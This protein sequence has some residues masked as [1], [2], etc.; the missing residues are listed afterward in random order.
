MA[1]VPRPSWE[2]AYELRRV[3]ARQKVYQPLAP[4]A[5]AL[6]TGVAMD[7]V[8]PLG[9]GWWALAVVAL[10]GWLVGFYQQRIQLALVAVL[11]AV[12]AVGGAWSHAQW[13]LFDRTELGRYAREQ[14]SPVCLEAIALDVPARRPAPPHSPY[15]AIPQRDSTKLP[16]RVTRIRDGNQWQ[17]AAGVVDLIVDGHLEGVA[18]GDYLRLFGQLRRPGKP[19]NPGQFDFAANAR[20]D[21]RLALLRCESPACVTRVAPARAE[22]GS[23]TSHSAPSLASRVWWS[24][25]AARQSVELGLEEQLG[26]ER[27]P[28]AAAMLLGSRHRVPLNVAE[29]FRRTGALHVLVVS[30][31]HVGLVVGFFFGASRLGWFPRRSTLMLIMLAIAAYALFT[32]ARPPVVRAAV[33]AEVMCVAMLAGRNVLAINSLAAAVIVVLAWNPGELFLSGTQLTFIATA[34]LIWLGNRLQQRDRADPMDRLLASVES[35]PTRFAKRLLNS[36][37]LLLLATLFVWCI[38]APLLMTRFHLLSPIAV[39]MSLGVFPLV[40]VTVIAALLTAVLQLFSPVLAAAPAWCCGQ[41]IDALQAL[42]SSA[43][44][45]PGST[46]WLGGPSGWWTLGA[47]GLLTMGLLYGTRERWS[48]WLSRMGLLWIATGFVIALVSNRPPDGVRCTFIAVGHGCSVLVETPEGGALLYDAGSLG[49]P[50]AAAE[51]IAGALWSKGIGRIDAIVLSHPDVDHF[52]AVPGL[53]DRFPIG[54]IYV[55]PFM[56]PESEAEQTDRSAPASLR[57]LLNDHDVPVEVI[58]QGD[59]LTIDGVAIQI[60]HPGHADLGRPDNANSLVLAF[61]YQGRRLLLP[62]DLEAPGMQDVLFQSSYNCDLLLAP[63]HGSA[64]SDPP[65]FAKWSSPEWVVVSGGDGRYSTSAGESYAQAG[66]CVLKT[67]DVGAIEVLLGA[68]QT[69]IK[70]YLPPPEPPSA[71]R[72]SR[73]VTDEAHPQSDSGYSSL[74]E[75]P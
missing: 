29:S 26:P 71:G 57:K 5:V 41:S 51:T 68:W 59:Q 42:I 17:P 69:S 72:Q 4:V 24:I 55:S 70:T 54:G 31:L 7:R 21:H 11:V 66:A 32:G 13:R 14:S 45:V 74:R 58:S 6:A 75:L 10:A 67:A 44:A 50:D 60:L 22:R 36:A 38:S 9:A 65:G 27:A 1:E 48:Y 3:T 15:R 47:Y 39:P 2:S 12:A 30:G 19:R 56:F 37:S 61:E 8:A 73:V 64:R 63:H 52:N 62:G 18:P 49:S 16:L 20:A 46:I 23:P 43:E 25:A 34:A 33:L 28:L 53:L 40:S 35:W